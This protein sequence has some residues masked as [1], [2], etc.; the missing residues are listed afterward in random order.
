ME[1]ATSTVDVEA[2]AAEVLTSLGAGS[3]LVPFSS[4]LPGFSLDDAWR[5]TP[6]LR[7]AFEARGERIL[8]RKLGFTNRYIWPQYNIYAP[9]WG[10]V[11]DATVRD[12]AAT[13]TLALAP[14]CEPRI[15]PE[16]MFHL[17][18]MPSPGMDDAEILGCIDWLA[19]GYEIVHS[20]YPGWVFTAPDTVSQNALHGALLVGPHREVAPR[21]DEFLAELSRFSVDLECNGIT[22]DRGGGAAV[23]EGPLSTVRHLMELL[24]QDHHNPPLAAGEILST[25]TLTK[26]F[27]VKRGDRWT[28]TFRGIPLAPITLQFD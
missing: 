12:L 1:A 13:G 10:Y 20:L 5:V 22:I 25:G 18:Q 14:F 4:R 19:A 17:G 9:N 26:A 28:A 11:T 15:E 8:G 21:K 24:A 7:A 6:L 27:P 3:S 16:I 2:I 23:L